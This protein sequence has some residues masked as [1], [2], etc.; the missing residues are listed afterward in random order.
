MEFVLR[1]N[2]L[3]RFSSSYAVSCI[4]LTQSNVSKRA[5][6]NNQLLKQAYC[7]TQYVIILG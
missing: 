4:N 1:N 6:Y 7:A 3:I 5:R 2:V